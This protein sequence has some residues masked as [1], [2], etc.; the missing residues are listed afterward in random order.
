MS[1]KHFHELPA[2]KILQLIKTNCEFFHKWDGSFI[3][4]GLDNG[5]FYSEWKRNRRFYD[6][7]DYPMKPWANYYRIV[8]RIFQTILYQLM[9][10]GGCTKN[11]TVDMEII[12]GNRP[13]VAPEGNLR[14]LRL[15]I[16]SST[17]V[18]S[19]ERFNGF[20]R[21]R[22]LKTDN[23]V[24]IK[25]EYTDIEWYTSVAMSTYIKFSQWDS[26]SNHL[27]KSQYL[28]DW[29]MTNSDILDINL[30]RSYE[31]H[32]LSKADFT[33]LV[34]E[35]RIEIRQE[36]RNILEDSF[37][38]AYA[39]GIVL[40]FQNGERYKVI[41]R[42]FHEANRFVHF[43]K[44]ALVGGR[45]PERPSFWTRTL[46]WP[47]EKRLERLEVLRKRFVKNREKLSKRFDNFGTIDYTE[48]QIYNRTLLLFAEVR[49]R[50]IHG[51]SSI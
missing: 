24:S 18:P 41:Q 37:L 31:G 9:E 16:H 32:S 25:F 12:D 8:H 39:E 46:D 3:R 19:F 21:D 27:K 7:S 17:V 48:P 11:E 13:N 20:I 30:S 2:D 38:Y 34:K 40:I 23:G 5:V 49:E 28:G 1:I 26:L 51:W 15:V 50:V 44:Y 35:K 42:D 33:K 10:T 4:V 22:I 6:V 47:V 29:I 43:V 45:R 36:I 14:D